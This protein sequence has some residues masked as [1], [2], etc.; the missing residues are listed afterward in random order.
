MNDGTAR[1]GRRG[2][3][4]NGPAVSLPGETAAWQVLCLRGAAGDSL[5]SCR[6]PGAPEKE[7]TMKTSVPIVRHD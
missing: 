3:L 2:V 6:L 5:G 4:S 7:E 1:K